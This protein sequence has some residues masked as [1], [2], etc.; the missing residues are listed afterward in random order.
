MDRIERIFKID[1]LLHA[2]ESTPIK[3][4]IDELE[5]SRA[6]VVRDL[7]YMRDRLNA[8]I[9]WDQ[10]CRGYRYEN[11]NPAFPRYSLPGLWLSSREIYA[12]LTMEQFLSHLQPSLLKPLVEPLRIRIRNL[13]EGSDSSVDELFQRIRIIRSATPPVDSK[14]FQI[15]ASALFN[16]NQLSALYLNRQTNELVRRNISPQRLVHYRENWY[17]DGWCHLRSDLR[18]FRLANFTE[19]EITAESA[20]NVEE[21]QLDIELE[22]G[23]GIFAGGETQ[24]AVLRFSKSLSRWISKE[25]WHSNQESEFDHQGRLILTIPFSDDREI[26]ATILQYGSAVEILA[27]EQLRSTIKS[28]LCTMSAIYDN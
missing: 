7:A 24:Q 13:L 11:P 28:K 6:T 18:T 25:K 26:I 20:I 19:A 16:R 2:R 5:V 12:L 3:R 10:T 21:D 27:P 9:V 23:F 1:Q 22:S 8:P 14:I 4:I 17:L 15:V